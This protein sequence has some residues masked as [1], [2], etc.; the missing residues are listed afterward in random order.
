MLAKR[1]DQGSQPQGLWNA[2]TDLEKG[3]LV[4]LVKGKDDPKAKEV[5]Y[6]TTDDE[7][8]GF[9]TLRIDDN[10]GSEILDNNTIPAGKKPVIYTLHKH[11]VWLTTEVDGAEEMELGTKLTC[12]AEGKLVAGDGIFEV[13]EVT[14]AAGVP[15]IG[16]RIIK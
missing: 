4:K 12:G 7:A 6:A 15:A 10:V 14:K 2:Q 11:N 13:V 16:V 8:M 9:C 1:F 5:V 3:R